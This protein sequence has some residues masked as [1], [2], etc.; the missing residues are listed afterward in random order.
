MLSCRHHRGVA[1]AAINRKKPWEFFASSWSSALFKMNPAIS[2]VETM[3]F[4]LLQFQRPTTRPMISHKP[5]WTPIMP[6]RLGTMLVHDQDTL[7]AW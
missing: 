4:R 3:R 1:F 6:P 2:L 5:T 7:P